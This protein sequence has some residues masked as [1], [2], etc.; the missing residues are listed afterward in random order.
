MHSQAQ[1]VYLPSKGTASGLE[2]TEGNRYEFASDEREI[3]LGKGN[4]TQ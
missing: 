2:N 3:Y 4:T 1:Q